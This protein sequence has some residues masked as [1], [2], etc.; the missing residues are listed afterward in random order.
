MA[1]SCYF[2]S[3]DNSSFPTK[4]RP[5]SPTVI[6]IHYTALDYSTVIN[7]QLTTSSRS[8]D[9]NDATGYHYVISGSGLIVE[10]IPSLVQ[11]PNL[12]SY[13]DETWANK[14]SSGNGATNPDEIAIHVILCNMALPSTEIGTTQY[15]SLVRLL[16][17]LVSAY[18]T[19]ISPDSG[20]IILPNEIDIDLTDDYDGTSLPEDLFT[21]ISTCVSGGV[22]SGGGSGSA[23]CCAD[24][25]DLIV[26]LTGRVTELEGNVET[27]TSD[28]ATLETLVGTIDAWKTATTATLA[29]V[30]TQ[31][32]SV[33]EQV[34]D[35]AEYLGSIKSC[36]DTV[37]PNVMPCG[38][39]AYGL[40]VPENHQLVIPN[41]NRR[42]NFA[43]EISDLIPKAVRVG[44]LWRANLNQGNYTLEVTAQL[45]SAAYAAGKKVW[46]ELVYCQDTVRIAEV[47]LN[48]GTQIVNI[49]SDSNAYGDWNGSLAIITTC[50]DFHIEIGTDD[51]TG[52]KTLGNA[53]IVISPVI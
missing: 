22:G 51:A 18:D 52:T 33:S 10:M 47:T 42:I 40:A 9:Y 49:S 28:L 14:P 12:H 4:T 6:V 15:L 32:A 34:D 8:T 3:L 31:V 5:G 53:S 7:R 24:N 41:I 11:V 48:A 19:T 50:S 13:N 2:P 37:C 35:N 29:T 27:L 30:Q 17:C 20:R 21:D 46:L 39:I 23:S 38:E 25:E 45:A 44:P 36:L 16:C 1:T 26:A 43:E